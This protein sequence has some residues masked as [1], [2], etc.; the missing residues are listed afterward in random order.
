MILTGAPIGA[1]DALR[2]GLVTKVV[3]PA[4]LL[5]AAEAIAHTIAGKG[6]LA[7]RMSLKALNA[8]LEL[9]LSEGLK[10][11]AALFGESCGTEDAREGIEAF[12]QKRKPQFKGK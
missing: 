5:A 4:G 2:I 8:T 12:L 6:K 10:V 1:H 11:E 9:P 7:V 3:P